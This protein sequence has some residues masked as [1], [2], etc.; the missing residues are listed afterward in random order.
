[1]PYGV[2][3]VG[4]EF[5]AWGGKAHEFISALSNSGIPLRRR[6]SR[7]SGLGAFAGEGEAMLSRALLLAALSTAH[8]LFTDANQCVDVSTTSP[9]G[10]PECNDEVG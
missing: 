2:W 6:E 1:M 3:R 8:A 9:D 5:S 7:L 10:S 4:Y